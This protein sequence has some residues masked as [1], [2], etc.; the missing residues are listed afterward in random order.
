[1]LFADGAGAVILEE[2]DEPGI[3][4]THLHA[5]GRYEE[6]LHVPNAQASSD[7]AQKVEAH[8]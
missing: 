5:D 8:I 3:L 6:L 2:S 7:D 1:M 4:S